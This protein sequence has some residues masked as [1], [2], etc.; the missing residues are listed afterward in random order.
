MSSHS[1]VLSD[2]LMVDESQMFLTN[3]GYFD[4]PP[5]MI[6]IIGIPNDGKHLFS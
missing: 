2:N 5:F 6:Q 3:M 4:F 1:L